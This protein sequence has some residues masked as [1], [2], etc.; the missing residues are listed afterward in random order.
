MVC[1]FVFLSGELLDGTLAKRNQQKT[2][3]IR[4]HH[5]GCGTNHDECAGCCLGMFVEPA[6]GFKHA[7][8]RIGGRLLADALHVER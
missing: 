7:V 8:K 4:D 2:C 6:G 3:P 5:K 1:F